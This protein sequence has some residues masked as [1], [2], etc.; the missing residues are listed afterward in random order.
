MEFIE[1]F[2]NNKKFEPKFQAKLKPIFLKTV[3]F[4]ISI[5][6]PKDESNRW[7]IKFYLKFQNEDFFTPLTEVWNHDDLFSEK[8]LS[9]LIKKKKFLKMLLD[10]MKI[11]IKVFPP[12][13][14]VLKNKIPQNI[15][16]SSSEVSEFLTQPIELLKYIGF[17]VLFPTKL[18]LAQK[19]GLSARLLIESKSFTSN[20]DFSLESLVDFRW[21]INLFGKPIG[22]EELKRLS[23]M[24][25][26]LIKW[27]DNKWI[28]INKEDLYFLKKI[29]A[30]NGFSGKIKTA[31][32]KN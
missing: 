4:Y 13:K 20:S 23:K 11:A 25:N 30:S 7:P 22:L 19:R 15:E 31:E 2:S 5:E 14:R 17:K 8:F 3:E 10:S 28:F 29:Y 16:M 32:K 6:L 12:L 9:I 21:E 27:R 18:R 1:E 24:D 26:P